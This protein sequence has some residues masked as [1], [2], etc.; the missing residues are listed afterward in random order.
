[1]GR[2]LWILHNPARILISWHGSDAAFPR[3]VCDTRGKKRWLTTVHPSGPRNR[4]LLLLAFGK[5][6]CKP[7][8]RRCG[9]N[10]S[11]PKHRLLVGG[12]R[13]EYSI[14]PILEVTVKHSVAIYAACLTWH[15]ASARLPGKRFEAS[16][17][18][19]L[20]KR[21]WQAE[22]NNNALHLDRLAR[23]HLFQSFQLLP[24]QAKMLR[25]VFSPPPVPLPSRRKKMRLKQAKATRNISQ[26]H[27]STQRLA[28]ALIN[29]R[30]LHI[31]CQGVL[32][33]RQ[34]SR[35]RGKVCKVSV[36]AFGKA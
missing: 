27:A 6:V 34:I 11:T 2:L 4:Q 10:F 23:E 17:L 14:C 15:C 8:R 13:P 35:C 20:P 1:M 5:P 25:L 28:R 26:R 30:R 7:C 22:K 19:S 3:F 29:G 21:F 24:T 36:T 32:H 12:V 18:M 33:S 31:G 9:I 16:T